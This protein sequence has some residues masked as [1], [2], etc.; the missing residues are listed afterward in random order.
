MSRVLKE[1][2]LVLDPFCGRAT[3][4]VAAQN[5]NRKWI[6]IDI[7]K[8]AGR[9][10]MN[11]LADN[12]GLF[13]DFVHIDSLPIRTDIDEIDVSSKDI[14]ETLY[15]NQNGK[16]NACETEMDIRHFEIDHIIPRSKNGGEFLENLQLLCGSCNKIKG[17]RPIAYLIMRIEKMNKIMKFKVSFDSN[18]E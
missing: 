3:T 7:S 10:V 17:D 1:G 11:R 12:S 4:C 13:D 14:K 2:D 5:L 18:I 9:L 16:C 15:K 8:T 6:G